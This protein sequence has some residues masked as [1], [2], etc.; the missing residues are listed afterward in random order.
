MPSAELQLPS[1]RVTQ[2]CSC[3]TPF[4]LTLL[5]LAGKLLVTPVAVPSAAAAAASTDPAPAAATGANPTLSFLSLILL[6]T[7]IS[8][9]SSNLTSYMHP[10]ITTLSSFSCPLTLLYLTEPPPV[11]T[12]SSSCPPDIYLISHTLSISR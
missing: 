3:F 5:L 10:L 12:S 9:I 6:T 1:I 11:D 7:F 2:A 4:H 8:Y